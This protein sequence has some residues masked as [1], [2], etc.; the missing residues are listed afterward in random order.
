MR[1]TTPLIAIVLAGCGTS[2]TVKELP[3]SAEEQKKKDITPEGIVVNQRAIYTGKATVKVPGLYSEKKADLKLSGVDHS[4]I[5]ELNVAR[6][7]FASGKLAIK[8]DER[9][10]LKETSITSKT[11]G[12]DVVKTTTT[13]VTE[14]KKIREDEKKD[15]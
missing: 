2:L 15:D 7:W 12:A 8:L 3:R 5:V 1:Y 4:N 10:V 6:M 14:R 11:G 13:I 9:G